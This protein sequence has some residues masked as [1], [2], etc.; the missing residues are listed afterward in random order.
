[1]SGGREAKRLA[2]RQILSIDN[3]DIDD[4]QINEEESESTHSDDESGTDEESR[5]NVDANNDEGHDITEQTWSGMRW[6]R[7]LRPIRHTIPDNLF[8][9]PPEELS[10]I[11]YFK[12]FLG[13][14]A[15]DI[16]VDETNRYSVEKCGHS[17]NVTRHEMWKYIAITMTM[18]IV[19]LPTMRMYWNP[20][21]RIGIIADTM[22]LNR[23]E[24]IK[25][26]FH[27]NNNENYVPRGDENH[28]PLFKVRPLLDYIRNKCREVQPEKRQCVDE[29]MTK[30]KGRSVLR[31]YMPRKPI[32]WGIKV[33]ARCGESGFIHDFHIDGDNLECPQDGSLGYTGDVVMLLCKTLPNEIFYLYMDRFYTSFPLMSKLA[34]QNIFTIG[35]IMPNRLRKCP[36]KPDKELQKR[37]EYDHVVDANSNI[38]VVKWRDNRPVLVTSNFAA[39][40]PMSTCKRYSKE[41][42]QRI[43]VQCPAI[44]KE[45]SAHMGGVDL[46]DM[47]KGLYNIDR[48]GYKNYTRICH[49]L[50]GVCVINGWIIYR[51]HC[52]Q[53][54]VNSSDML[55][56]L[57]SICET[58]RNQPENQRPRGRPSNDD[59]G[60]VDETTSSKRRCVSYKPTEEIRTDRTQPHFPTHTNRG[61]CRFC[62]TGHT[63]LM[64]QT[65]K[66]RLCLT[67]EK[68]CFT[69]Y[70]APL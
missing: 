47:L 52:K 7:F 44:I 48:R 40:E 13:D 35:T 19:K 59:H 57:G 67:K 1:M 6:R 25:R 64:C 26:Y 33:I 27:I 42:K 37:G 39:V 53:K 65:C 12:Q 5:T 46:F 70:H 43:D 2:I 36:I 10:P 23:F 62:Q 51:R 34:S 38:S 4:D 15:I 58:L 56:F 30:F 14:D 17:I 63:T 49:Y 61:R 69:D 29:Q 3:S 66:M 55:K 21:Y 18:G 45:Y 9:P 16:L 31:R 8:D 28:D 60:R 20:S 68:N 50:F 11:A 32:K 24:T 41:R 22:G 54:G